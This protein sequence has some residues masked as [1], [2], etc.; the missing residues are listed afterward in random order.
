MVTVLKIIVATFILLGAYVGL[1]GGG[2]I[3][4]SVTAALIKIAAGG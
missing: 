4:L 1:L 2:P 3:G